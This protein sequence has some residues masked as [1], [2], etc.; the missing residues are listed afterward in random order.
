MLKKIFIL[1]SVIF[2]F[3]SS[4][5]F[6]E[7]KFIIKTVGPT[8][9]PNIKGPSISAPSKTEIDEMKRAAGHE[10]FIVEVE[11]EDEGEKKNKEEGNI[12]Q[13]FLN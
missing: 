2:F 6:S 9:A 3:L 4:S 11:V 10:E 12:F 8:S 1:F 5:I 13:Q 7:E